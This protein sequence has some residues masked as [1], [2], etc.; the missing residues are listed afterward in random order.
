MT[1]TFHPA[2]AKLSQWDALSLESLRRHGWSNEEL[3]RRV[4]SGELPEDDSKFRFTYVDLVTLAREQSEIF[5]QA[6]TQG[7]QIKF[8]TLGGSR[9]WLFLV[10]NREAELISEPGQEAV[11]ASLTEAEAERLASV[12]SFGWTVKLQDE[13]VDAD[14]RA[15]YRVVPVERGPL[16]V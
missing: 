10:L 2:P 16:A 1:D 5:T 3:I 12:L 9:S 13:A 15:V 6:V 8:S 14:G 11:Q 4:E 7:Y